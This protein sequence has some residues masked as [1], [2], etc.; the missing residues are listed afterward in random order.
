MKKN[1]KQN[2]NVMMEMD[3][4]RESTNAWGWPVNKS[5]FQ[6]EKSKITPVSVYLG[7]YGTNPWENVFWT[8]KV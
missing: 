1:T 7:T 4:I 6:Q 5:F 3:G 2:A 8:A